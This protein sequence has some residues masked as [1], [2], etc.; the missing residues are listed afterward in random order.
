MG[1]KQSSEAGLPHSHGGVLLGL[2]RVAHILANYI[3]QGVL[4]YILL[5][6]LGSGFRA[7]NY[8]I[9]GAGYIYTLPFWW[10]RT[11]LTFVSLIKWRS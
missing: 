8:E 2:C 10:H 7:I 6:T 4:M 11:Q 5:G 9:I 1:N 3:S